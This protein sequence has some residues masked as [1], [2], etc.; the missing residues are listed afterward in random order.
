[1]HGAAYLLKVSELE[2]IELQWQGNAQKKPL[3]PF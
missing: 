2:E 1:M 3:G